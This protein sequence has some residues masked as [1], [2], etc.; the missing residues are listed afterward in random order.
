MTKLRV[1]VIFGG[2][3]GEHEVSIASAASIF[4]H[5]DPER[6]EAV[7]IRIEKDGRWVLS[8]T[9]PTARSAAAV[10]AESRT[11]LLEEPAASN[12]L[13]TAGAGEV[14]PTAALRTIARGRRVPGSPRPVRRG[15]HR[16]G[17]ARAR[18]RALRGRRRAR[19]GGRH[20]QGGDEDGCL[21]PTVFR[22]CRT[23][24]RCSR[25]WDRDAAGVTA[26]VA[27]G[28]RLSRVRQAGQPRLERRHLEGEIGA[29]SPTR[30]T[31][32]LQFD[33]K[34]V[35]EAGVPQAREIECAVLGNDDPEASVP[36]EIIVTHADG[37]YSYDAKYLDPKARRG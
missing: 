36:G 29:S 31:L 20:G 19:V 14:E 28:A 30:S 21:P 34:I 26:R 17:A 1:G 24:S 15:R 2:R 3:S 4:T 11:T 25:D 9:A 23:S 22:S 27:A 5:L 7:P 6:Y 8:A 16:A 12:T 18:G 33:R 32:A 13:V 10:I 37:F 35:I